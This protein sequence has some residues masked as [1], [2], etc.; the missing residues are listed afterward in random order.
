[1]D[2]NYDIR[3]PTG[4]S[5][6]ISKIM[7][8]DLWEEICFILTETVPSNVSEQIYENKVIRVFEKLGWSQ[9]KNELSV[10]ESI[11]FGAANRM[12]P[13]IIIRNENAE[14]VCVIEIKKPTEDLN[15]S[16][17][18]NQLSSYMRML[19]TPVGILIGDRMK[20]FTE[21]PDSRANE[22]HL[23]EEIPLK[24]SS[25]KGVEFVESFKKTE[26]TNNTI[27]SYLQNGLKK[28][29][30]E[31][32]LKEIENRII[33]P[34][35]IDEI[36]E[37]VKEK[38]SEFYD[39]ELVDR[40]LEDYDFEIKS[41][42]KHESETYSSNKLKIQR[43]NSN[44]LDSKR[45]KDGLKIGEYVQ[46]TFRAL[47]AQ[48][49]LNSNDIQNLLNPDYSKRVFNAGYAVLRIKSQ[50]RAD[51]KGYNRYYKEIFGER[52]FLSA[53][54]NVSHWDLFEKWLKEINQQGLP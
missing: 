39:S 51:Q 47:F 50:G 16:G 17:H 37:L 10:R 53:Q 29:N 36:L 11:Q 41:K 43:I 8:K 23:V 42:A 44:G 35:F 26:N 1:M 33:Q 13:D 25:E 46:K 38:L 15:F 21:K 48:G 2:E 12:C 22:I 19:R 31:Q 3:V 7:D 30:E 40:I 18:V 14:A 45:T 54:W 27:E 52:Y 5:L 34:G 32:K 9:Y 6:I 49:K 4:K 20:I 28:H 24:R